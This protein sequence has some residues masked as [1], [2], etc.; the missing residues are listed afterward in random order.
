MNAT[1]LQLHWSF[2]RH[3]H[4]S[5]SL[6]DT[7]G[8]ATCRF[9]PKLWPE[10]DKHHQKS[11]CN[12]WIAV[13][14]AREWTV[15]FEKHTWQRSPIGLCSLVLSWPR[16]SPVSAPTFG[17][18]AYQLGRTWHTQTM[19]TRCLLPKSP[20]RRSDQMQK[21]NLIP[22]N[23]SDWVSLSPPMLFMC[24]SDIYTLIKTSGT[25][26]KLCLETS[27]QRHHC[28]EPVYRFLGFR[29]DIT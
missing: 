2:C 10:W 1:S 16:T 23:E 22:I 25:L 27:C 5:Q 8:R 17:V 14:R 18:P 13:C 28:S 24:C 9:S 26:H 11:R 7:F 6:T 3:P 15:A 29:S 19:A 20:A 21:G 12:I 4:T